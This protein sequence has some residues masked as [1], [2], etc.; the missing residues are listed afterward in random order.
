[1]VNSRD[2]AVSVTTV[3]IH[4]TAPEAVETAR[5]GSAFPCGMFFQGQ[6]DHPRKGGLPNQF[7]AASVFAA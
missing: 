7:F 4:P 5:A 1:M 2:R 3:T 6:K